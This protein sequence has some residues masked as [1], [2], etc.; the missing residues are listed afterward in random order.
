MEILVVDVAAAGATPQDRASKVAVIRLDAELVEMERGLFDV[1]DGF[2]GSAYV[3]SRWIDGRV[4]AAYNLPFVQ[5]LLEAGYKQCGYTLDAGQGV[6][7]KLEDISL[8]DACVKAGI[9]MDWYG[10]GALAAA[11][12]AAELLRRQ[13]DQGLQS[14]TGSPALVT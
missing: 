8:E 10:S 5:R 3:L 11:E 13:V 1:R 9:V 4:L 14:L 6:D 7:L 2:C 12:E